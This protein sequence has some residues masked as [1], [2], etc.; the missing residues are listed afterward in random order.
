MSPVS[1]RQ[2]TDGDQKRCSSKSPH[3]QSQVQLRVIMPPVCRAIT[4]GLPD[5][6]PGVAAV[7]A[8][9]DFVLVVFVDRRVDR[10][11]AGGVEGEGENSGS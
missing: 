7:G 1:G 3:R 4:G 9:E 5:G 6:G 8:F 2:N 11:G 10:F